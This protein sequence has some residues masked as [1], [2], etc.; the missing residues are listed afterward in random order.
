MEPTLPFDILVSIVDLLAGG[1][2]G[3][4]KSL[5]ILS[6][7][8]KLM[9]PLCR[10]HLFSSIHLLDRYKSK[11]KRFNELLSHNPDIAHYVK[12]LDYMFYNPIGDHEL[13]I[14][15]TLKE[16]S[17]LQSIALRSLA[18][19][20]K[21]Y[22]E[23]MRSSLVSMIQLPTVTQ[24]SIQSFKGFPAAVLSYCSNLVDL[25]LRGSLQMAPPEDNLSISRSKIPALV[26]LSVA[27]TA[28]DSLALLL[29]SA[30]L[31]E[32]ATIVDFSHLQRASFDVDS[33]GR[34][35]EL[36]KVTK[37]LEYFY[38]CLVNMPT[39]LTGIGAT[40]AINAYHTLESLEVYL[41]IEGDD[42]DPLCGL[43]HELKFLTG[44]N[45]LKELKLDVMISNP[46]RPCRTDSEDWSALDSVLTESGAFPML[47]QVSINISWFSMCGIEVPFEQLKED[48]FPRLM[49]SKVVQFRLSAQIDDCCTGLGP[50]YVR[51][52]NPQ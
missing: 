11:S 39:G 27:D 41:D 12:R 22:P 13:K 14:L 32:C 7:T 43:S 25:Q 29:N 16:G 30:S 48:K 9:V 15:E 49:E 51:C 3:N 34:I 50:S 42:Y 35:I 24:L 45:V 10:K 17:P 52:N 21:D 33:P 5:Q 6:Q 47:R 23:A 38:I 18:V 4:I 36:I 8:C 28:Y 20:W 37:R 31:R 19:E 44:K 2:D 40:L 26:S 1:E 46:E